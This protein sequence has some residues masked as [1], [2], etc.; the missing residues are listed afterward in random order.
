MSGRAPSTPPELDG[1]TY[2]RLLGSGGFADVFLYEQ[3]KPRRKVAIKVLLASMLSPAALRAF[4]AEADLMAQLSGHP[5]I[6]TIFQVGRAADGRPY[7][8][9]QY[10]PGTNLGTRYKQ[11]ALGVPETLRIGVDI[12]SAVETA[13]RSG[14]LH[15]DIKP[16]NI[17]FT[18]YNE[19]QLTDFGIASTVEGSADAAGG[20]SLPW[21]PPESFDDPPRADVTT[22]V[23][24][25]GAT[26][27]TL[28][29]GRSPF[30][31]P[32]RSNT[33]TDLMA[34]IEQAA[35]TPTGRV[36]V[37]ASL[38]RVLAAAMGKRPEQRYPSALALARALQQVQSELGL[39]ATTI[40]VQGDAVEA[41]DAPDDGD[42]GT[43]IRRVTT[44]N[45]DAHVLSR[46]AR[47]SSLTGS[48]PGAT[49][50]PPSLVNQG[51][52]PDSTMDVSHDVSAHTMVR[53]AAGAWVAP[54]S[55]PALEET[56]HRTPTVTDA[57]VTA[58]P[59]SRKS[60]FRL[61]GLGLGGAVV[62]GAVVMAIA[63]GQHGAAPS[64]DPSPEVSFTPS[65]TLDDVVPAPTDVRAQQAGDQVVFTWV[66]PD[67]QPGD[68]Y[69]WR[70]LSLVDERELAQA[71]DPTV[72]VPIQDGQTCLEVY[73]TRAGK[74][75]VDAAKG[76]L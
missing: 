75:S 63:G 29:A 52:V 1:F 69:L 26:I 72:T 15:R 70:V 68:A 62:V 48:T 45:P 61:I 8:V 16:Q 17:L 5:S 31:L 67:P 33:S 50:P 19:P 46:P 25:L 40:S 13:H 36:D 39:G 41:V 66:N 28:L 54:P 76:C 11:G 51:P 14:I 7:L 6:V 49:P 37:P 20:M 9:M 60:R 4:D 24:A 73:L 47:P 56:I 53:G 59:E 43:R 64:I 65:D 27:Y 18:E 22:D 23:W 32:G 34:R 55:P 57:G 74:A 2:E 3:Q 42:P 38:E 71:A 35:L 10:C 44:I 12:A 30:E 58:E 21:S